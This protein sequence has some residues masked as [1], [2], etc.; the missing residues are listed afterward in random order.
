MTPWVTTENENEFIFVLK[1]VKAM[2]A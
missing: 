2:A 1:V